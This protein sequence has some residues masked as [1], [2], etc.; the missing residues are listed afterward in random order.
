MQILTPLIASLCLVFMIGCSPSAKPDGATTGQGVDVQT[1]AN[2]L[3][4]E[5]GQDGK[6]VFPNALSK[7]AAKA[8]FSYQE[9]VWDSRWDW[10]D[11]DGKLLGTVKGTETFTTRLDGTV[12]E[13]INDVPD[14]GPKTMAVMTYNEAEGKIIFFSMGAKGDYWVMKQDPVSGEMISQ[15]H[16]NP[17]GTTQIIRFTTQRKTD[18]QMDIVMESSKDGG[19]SWVKLFTQYMV[20]RT[21]D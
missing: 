14:M 7:P 16:I 3:S 11:P 21:K 5:V 19:R 10:V 8:L 12:Q 9:G 4:K 18:D 17:D 2:G 6:N 20:R 15:P 1:V 13:L